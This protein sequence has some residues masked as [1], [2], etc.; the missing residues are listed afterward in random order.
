MAGCEPKEP[1]PRTSVLSYTFITLDCNYPLDVP[2]LGRAALQGGP[3][4]ADQSLESV[5]QGDQP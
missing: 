1:G 3:H 2:R 5:A 4:A